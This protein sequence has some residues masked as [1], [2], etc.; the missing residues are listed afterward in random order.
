MEEEGDAAVITWNTGWI[1]KT[2]KQGS[3]YHTTAYRKSQSL[4]AAPA[5]S[6]DAQK[7]K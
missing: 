5:N 1:T 6:S 7:V 4:D 3:Q 2:T